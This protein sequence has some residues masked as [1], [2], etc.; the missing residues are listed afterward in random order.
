MGASVDRCGRCGQYIYIL[1]LWVTGEV[2]AIN[3]GTKPAL[4][5]EDLHNE[6][7]GIPAMKLTEAEPVEVFTRHKCN[8]TD[9]SKL[10]STK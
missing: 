3:A 2:I 8:G 7:A 4:M 10:K 1:Q 9:W 5:V 6:V